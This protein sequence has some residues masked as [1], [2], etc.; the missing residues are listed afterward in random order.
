MLILKKPG[1]R[2]K[3]DVGSSTSSECG[4]AARFRNYDTERT[5]PSLV[6][7]ALKDGYTITHK[8]LLCWMTIPSALKIFPLRALFLLLETVFGSLFSV[9]RNRDK[10]Y[11]LPSIC[12]W[13]PTSLSWD[14]CCSHVAIVELV[15]RE[16]DGLTPEQLNIKQV[17]LERR[18]KAHQKTQRKRRWQCDYAEAKARNFEAYLAVQ[19]QRAATYRQTQPAAKPRSQTSV[20][21]VSL[22][23]RLPVILTTLKH[24]RHS[25]A[26]GTPFYS[27]QDSWRL[28]WIMNVATNWMYVTSILSL[29]IAKNRIE[30]SS[31]HRIDKSRRIGGIQR[32]LACGSFSHETSGGYKF[33]FGC[34]KLY[35]MRCKRIIFSHIGA[36]ENQIVS[37]MVSILRISFDV[38]QY[39]RS[40]P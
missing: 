15:R 34:C 18:R 30:Q 22:L 1:Y 9:M 39:T 16:E 2:R 13:N 38:R 21:R 20:Q 36:G 6:E 35:D 28:Q 17:E 27:R 19:R 31:K 3:Q 40:V 14:G 33:L 11:G 10:T 12:P 8:G 4:V 24:R 23:Y 7:A 25:R 5:L 37:G 29:R 32:R 26:I